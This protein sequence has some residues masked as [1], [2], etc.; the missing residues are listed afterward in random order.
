MEKPPW[1]ETRGT[2]GSGEDGT[3]G[4]PGCQERLSALLGIGLFHGE[5]KKSG[6]H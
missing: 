1:R 3:G 5:L 4:G 6:N 2:W